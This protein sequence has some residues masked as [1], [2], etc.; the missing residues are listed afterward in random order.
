[1]FFRFCVFMSLALLIISCKDNTEEKE[2]N[3]T[4]KKTITEKAQTDKSNSVN[5]ESEKL[6]S[7]LGPLQK[8][9]PQCRAKSVEWPETDKQL[10]NVSE[11]LPPKI[12]SLKALYNLVV[13]RS[14]SKEAERVGLIKQY[15]RLPLTDYVKAQGGCKKYWLNLG[16]NRW[17]C[18]EKLNPDSRDI[19]LRK[20][21][22]IPR[23]RITPNRYGLVKNDNA[24]YF[25]N[26]EE[27]FAGK[28]YKTYGRGDMISLKDMR[29]E[30]GKGYWVTGK[31]FL[32]WD[33]D[34][35]G[36]RVPR[37][38]GV[39]L[40]KLNIN[41]PVAIIRAKSSGAKVYKFPGGPQ[42]K[43]VEPLKHYSVRAIYDKKRVQLSGK[44]LETLFYRV[45]EGWIYARRVLSA[46]P[47]NPPPGLKDCEKWIEINIKMQTMVAYE[48]NEPVY[49]APISS[50]NKRYPT[51]YG[52]FR[53]W[54]KKANDDMTSSSL[55]K[56]QYRVEEV[57]WAV[58]FFF[59][60]ALHGAYWHSNFGNR[61]SHGCVN[62]TPIDARWI[63]EWVEPN[64]PQGWLEVQVDE[65]SPLPGTIVVVRHKYKH[66][67]PFYR[68]ARKLAPEDEVERL[69]N[70]RKARM[71]KKTLRM[72]KNK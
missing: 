3:K 44:K 49:M 37:Y 18:G 27:M 29:S 21:P 33:K 14:P 2:A 22:I 56:E 8:P 43:G 11:I 59:G 57:P 13:R 15:S 40:R 70:I 4:D 50:G 41:L 54:L 31:K 25:R 42:K 63:Y 28:V 12:K 62:L 72:L 26:K 23:R 17:V 32:I 61:K 69:D 39:N 30:G 34:I 1:M 6:P 19:L 48:G 7:P 58:F 71:K 55:A 38:H 60:Q 36:Y 52:I 46:W 66:E 9:R 67:V 5:G 51:K 53:T 20:Q 35:L 47:G 45:K 10:A 16:K 65:K 64:V 24:P 68:Y